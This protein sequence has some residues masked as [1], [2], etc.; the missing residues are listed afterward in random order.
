M[1]NLIVASFVLFVSGCPA[2]HGRPLVKK[3][4]KE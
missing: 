3:G 4:G 2:F 1:A